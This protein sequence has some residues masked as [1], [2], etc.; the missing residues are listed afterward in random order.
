MQNLFKYCWVNEKFWCFNCHNK[1][2]SAAPPTPQKQIDIGLSNNLKKERAN[3]I[4]QKTGKLTH[5]QTIIEFKKNDT[6]HDNPI[7]DIYIRNN[8]DFT[9]RAFAVSIPAN[10]EIYMKFS[11]S[12][13]NITLS[14]LAQEISQYGICEGI[15]NEKILQYTYQRSVTKTFI[16][17][18]TTPLT[19]T[20]FY[21]SSSCSYIC[22]TNIFTNCQKFENQKN[23]C[24]KIH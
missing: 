11:K 2:P 24:S 18:V 13:K 9:I 20:K 5:H 21:R 3:F 14:N 22:K 6:N 16:P 1:A 7:F 8:L 4:F 15:K 12:M 10:H 19:F 23:I 17:N